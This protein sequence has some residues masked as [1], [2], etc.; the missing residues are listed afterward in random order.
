MEASKGYLP[1]PNIPLLG[2]LFHI[3]DGSNEGHLE[4]TSAPSSETYNLRPALFMCF[5]CSTSKRGDGGGLSI[6]SAQTDGGTLLKGFIGRTRS[7]D[8]S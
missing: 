5:R 2:L 7:V 1:E 3:T 6:P 4:V 8:K